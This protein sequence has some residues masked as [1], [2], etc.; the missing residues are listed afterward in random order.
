MAVRRH[1]AVAPDAVLMREDLPQ[2]RPVDLPAVA[3]PVGRRREV[4]LVPGPLEPRQVAPRVVDARVARAV[5]LEVEVGD[6]A[7]EARD[8]APASFWE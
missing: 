1:R 8:L 3:A 4:G 6:E 7:R 5:A 2:V